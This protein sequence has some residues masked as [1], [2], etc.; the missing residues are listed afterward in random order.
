M[1]EASELGLLGDDFKEI[2]EKVKS[3]K[4][5]YYVETMND[6][7]RQLRSTYHPDVYLDILTV[8]LA[9]QPAETAP[10]S[11]PNVKKTVD[12][13]VVSKNLSNIM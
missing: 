10:V 12:T 3:S 2:A 9:N 11:Q 6:V 7:Q 13:E 5:Y 1:V 8:K 4:V